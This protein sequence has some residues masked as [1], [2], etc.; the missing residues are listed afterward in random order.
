MNR[1]IIEEPQEVTDN[2]THDQD[3]A[4]DSYRCS[5]KCQTNVEAQKAL[6]DNT[7]D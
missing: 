2:R 7:N 3:P 4:V 5:T 1:F 6:I